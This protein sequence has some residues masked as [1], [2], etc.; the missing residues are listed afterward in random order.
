MA[1]M[2]NA[3]SNSSE[4]IVVAEKIFEAAT[5]GKNQLRYIA[6]PDAEQIIAARKELNDDNYMAMMKQ[7]MGL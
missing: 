6:G 2:K 4:P 3:G 1:G 5:D 7:Q